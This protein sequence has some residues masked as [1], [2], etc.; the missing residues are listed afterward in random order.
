MIPIFEEDVFG[1]ISRG[2]NVFIGG[3]TEYKK[4]QTFNEQKKKNTNLQVGMYVVSSTA[5]S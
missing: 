5:I 3:T 4:V 1:G 2:K